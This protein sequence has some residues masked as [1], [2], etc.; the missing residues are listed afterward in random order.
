MWAEIEE[1]WRIKK[2]NISLPALFTNTSTPP[3]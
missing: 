2:I 3:N 1:K